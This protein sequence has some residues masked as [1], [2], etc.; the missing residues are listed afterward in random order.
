MAFFIPSSVCER[1]FDCFRSVTFRSGTSFETKNSKTVLLGKKNN[2]S[3][4]KHAYFMSISEPDKHRRSVLYLMK[5]DM[6]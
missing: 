5:P 6:T 4:L 3:Y 1:A 2:I